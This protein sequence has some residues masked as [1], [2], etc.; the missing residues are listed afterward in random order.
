M[1]MWGWFFVAA[2]VVVVLLA[3]FLGLG[4]VKNRRTRKLREQFGPEYDRTVE[5]AGEQRTAEKELAA[6]QRTHDKLDIVE[7]AP[8]AREQYSTVWRSVQAAFV[9]S[10]AS[11]VRDADRLVTEVMRDRGYP[12]DDFDRRAADISVDHPEVV[13]NYRCAHQIYERQGDGDVATDDQR[14]AFVHYR[15][16]FERLLGSD[17]DGSEA[18]PRE[19]GNDKVGRHQAKEARS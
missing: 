6:R 7:L 10:P 5:Q 1:P 14:Q 16:L 9:D 12:V 3:V 2:A 8:E 19:D 18:E 17:A 15:A 13:E 4:A 11:A